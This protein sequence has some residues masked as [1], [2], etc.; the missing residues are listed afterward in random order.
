VT[1]DLMER[2]ARANPVSE[3]PA[4]ASPEGLRDLI[5]DDHPFSHSSQSP[6]GGTRIGRR[7]GRTALAG[8]VLVVCASVTT[9]LLVASSSNSGLNVLAA[10]YAA[11]VPKPG[12]TEAVTL[13]HTYG[14][15]GHDRVARLREWSDS[16]SH[17]RRGLTTFMGSHSHPGVAQ[18][19]VVYAPGVWEAWS[20]ARGSS[21]LPRSGRP[22][23]VH[24]IRWSGS[25]HPNDE[26]MGFLG[27][28]LVG[29]EWS[30]LYRGLYRKGQMRVVGHE[31]HSGRLLWKLE[32]SPARARA[33]ARE[34]HTQF[35]VLVDPH[36]FLPVYTRL[37]NLALKGH[38]TVS[39]SELLSYR[40]LA[41]TPASRRALDI[42]LQ[43]PGA[44]V[45][46]QAGVGPSSRAV[47][48]H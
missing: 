6:H 22:N 30:Q 23:V 34:D 21:F 27:G 45:V 41:S 24:R 12:I 37:I 20:N 1:V 32:A 48:K 7:R 3:L 4:V 8:L 10:V 31:R 9:V 25:F 47:P 5:E 42:V 44:Q 18:V 35:F 38:P 26:R 46:T 40:T 33:R 43:H 19:D 28:G 29:I 39:E 11:T 2:L 16:S 13:T 17:R 15:P 36:T 14:G